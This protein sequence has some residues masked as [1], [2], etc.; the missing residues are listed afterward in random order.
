MEP[1]ANPGKKLIINIEGR[2]FARYS[3]KT[4]LISPKDDIIS[5]VLEYAKPYLK[6]GD[7]LFLGEKVVAIT[8][9][10]VYELDKIKPGRLAKFLVSFVTKSPYGIGLSIPETMQLAV[11]EAGA[12]RIMLAAF[13]AALTKPFGIKG[14]FYRVA[15]PQA[16]GIDGPVDYAIPPYNKQASKIPLHANKVAKTIA[17]SIGFPVVIVDA[18]DIGAWV[19]G[20]S[21]GVEE[22]VILAALKDN[23]LGQTI[24]QTPIGILREIK[25]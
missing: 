6:K 4:H 8:Q 16:R 25:Q 15:G 5:V 1:K 20:K 12:L 13:L 22:K 2:N 23:P 24:E 11:E 19:V 7:I 3:V 21:K 9:N 17:D 14:V 10:R 18:C